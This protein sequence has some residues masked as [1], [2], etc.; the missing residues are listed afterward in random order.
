[1]LQGWLIAYCVFCALWGSLFMLDWKRRQANL[2]YR[3]GLEMV[4]ENAKPRKEFLEQLRLQNEEKVEGESVGCIG[5]LW[6]CD[7]PVER[8]N[9]LGQVE[10][11]YNSTVMHYARQMLTVFFVA[12]G[13]LIVIFTSLGV[14]LMRAR[15]MNVLA[16][17]S[18]AWTSLSYIDNQLEL[19]GNVD[20]VY[21]EFWT[22]Y[23]NTCLSLEDCSQPATADSI[24]SKEELVYGFAASSPTQKFQKTKEEQQQYIN[25]FRFDNVNT[26]ER[27]VSELI[28]RLV[29]N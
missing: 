24:A 16:G 10:V 28:K 11:E 8:I 26:I 5:A 23:D 4:E 27:Q 22:I 7:R 13:A 29:V 14:L 19:E 6:H 17:S 9:K 25:H 12:I 1:M 21:V 20:E 3:W 15:G 18:S 2:Q